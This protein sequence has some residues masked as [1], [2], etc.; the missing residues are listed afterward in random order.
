MASDIFEVSD[1]IAGSNYES[2]GS[3]EVM[4]PM[5]SVVLVDP[6]S[7][8]ER[9]T[10][11][12]MVTYTVQDRLFGANTIT[13]EL[14]ADWGPA[15][16]ASN[17][18]EESTILSFGDDALYKRPSSSRD[19]ART[20]Y[21]V[22][23]PTFTSTDTEIAD[24]DSTADPATMLT[25]LSP[26]SEG[27][28][29]I[30]VTGGMFKDDEIVVTYYNVKV[31][32][33]VA[34]M[35]EMV[36]LRVEDG[37]L[38]SNYSAMIEVIPQKLGNV[39]VTTE[40]DAV[41]AESTVDLTV[42]YTATKVLADGAATY[43]RIRV[44]LPKGW[45][46]SEDDGE[47]FKERPVGNSDATYLSLAKSSGVTLPKT[48]G[49]D[50]AL[51]VHGSASSGWIIDIDVD[52][53]T[54]R[55]QVTLTVHNLKINALMTPRTDR[56]TDLTDAEVA[57]KVHVRVSSSEYDEVARGEPAHSPA[58]FSPKD[59]E[60][61]ETQPTITVNRKTLGEVTVAPAS[62]T[63]GSEQDF[64]IT[65]KATEAMEEDDV[66]EIK[67]TAFLDAPTVYNFNTDGKHEDA[68]GNLLTTDTKGPHVHLSGSATRL[69]GAEITVIDDGGSEASAGDPNDDG[70]FVKIT[71]GTKGAAKNSTIV[72]KYN[73]ATVRRGLATGDDKLVV[74]TFSG[75]VVANDKPQFPVVKLAEDTIEV[76]HA[77]DGSGTVSFMY[78]GS[79]VTSMGGNIFIDD[80][81]NNVTGMNVESSEDN[82]IMELPLVSNTNVSIPAGVAKGDL[83]ELIVTY[84]PDGDMGAGEFEFRLPSDWKADDVRVSG[85]EKGGSG[86]TVTVDFD[87]HF[88]EADG[89]MVEITFADITVPKDYGEI[90]FTAKSKNAGGSPRQLSPR[91]MAFVGNAEATHDTVAVKITPAA[92]YENWDDVD[93]EIELTNAGPLHDSEIRITVPNELSGLQTDKAA[94]ANYVKMISTSARS[95]RLSTLDI[96]D[97]D[98]IVKTG[99]LNADGRIR[100]RFD[101]VDLEGVSTDA[102]TGFRV[103]TRTRGSGTALEDLDYASLDDEDYVEIQEENGDRSIAGG[104]IRTINGSGTMK[105]EPLTVEQDS[106]NET[107]K[108]TYTA[109]TDFE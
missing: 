47:I 102:P 92:A 107:I 104:L 89:D 7:V 42:R 49:K 63:A 87:V 36:S 3:V 78:E 84:T 35:P 22:V 13:I 41:T 57:D 14:P 71:L 39:T 54:T 69:E 20:S 55:H 86:N 23:K 83:R 19:R 77:A 67:L 75:P 72:L 100:V 76:K 10:V 81:G 6:Q 59:T 44:Q 9:D 65:Y 60:A 56:L 66:I 29:M 85:G 73:N 50:D 61:S 97:E 82:P 16:R 105:V 37:I 28:L 90:G 96:I 79:N 51:E 91:P 98:I 101:N 52:K 88:G 33:L 103:G 40:P 17:S 32:K 68:E 18:L 12:I 4:P 2:E 74:E 58:K 48:A 25:I 64:T 21:V 38:G 1:S 93:F 26:E 30:P 27:Y 31:Q 8:D 46:H 99:K 34:V 80:D 94:E 109:A 62:V 5:Q 15:H 43:G 45:T 108:L 24:H 106:R 11:D 70:W 53:M 95:V